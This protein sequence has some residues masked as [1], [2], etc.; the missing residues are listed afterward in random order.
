MRWAY[1]LKADCL[2]ENANYDSRS[3]LKRSKVKVKRLSNALPVCVRMSIVFL[4]SMATNHHF[5][6]AAVAL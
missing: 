3:R 5:I 1:M 4:V 2:A 6:S